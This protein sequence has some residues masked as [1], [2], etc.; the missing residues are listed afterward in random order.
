M[1]VP[2]DLSTGKDAES[3]DGE[4]S[5]LT[6]ESIQSRL[7]LSN[8]EKCLPQRSTFEALKSIPSH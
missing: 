5:T 8:Q 2:I 7:K 6:F 3:S 4:V 1:C